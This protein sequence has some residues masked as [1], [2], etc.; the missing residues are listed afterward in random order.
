MF[1]F[2]LLVGGLFSLAVVR[3]RNWTFQRSV[4]PII[5]S[6]VVAFYVALSWKISG[7]ESFHRHFLIALIPLHFSIVAIVDNLGASRSRVLRMVML[8]LA[9]A[10]LASSSI[11]FAPLAKAGDYRRVAQYIEQN[12][13]NAGL[14]AMVTS[15]TEYP[16]LFYYRGKNKIVP[17]PA[18]DPLERY[19]FAAWALESTDE[20]REKF[21]SIQS[22]GQIW[23]YADR[24][25]NAQFHGVHLGYELLEQVLAEDYTLLDERDFYKAKLRQFE[26]K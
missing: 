7:E 21:S 18:H 1:W 13:S 10:G 4:I 8:T 24:P 3:W 23:V 17:L 11:R 2:A 22:G 5:T 12:E 9:A 16:F 14:I 25:P 20:V 6:I 26:K 19:R 15:H